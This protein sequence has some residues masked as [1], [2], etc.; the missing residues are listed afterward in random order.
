MYVCTLIVYK[1]LVNKQ[2][3]KNFLLYEFYKSI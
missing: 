3:Y 1:K 2:F